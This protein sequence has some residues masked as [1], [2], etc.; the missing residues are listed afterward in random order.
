[1][2]RSKLSRLKSSTAK[3]A[4]SN[5]SNQNNLVRK[6][7]VS[8]VI[9]LSI[10]HWALRM[11]RR[12]GHISRPAWVSTLCRIHFRKNCDSFVV[13]CISSKVPLTLQ[14]WLAIFLVFYDLKRSSVA[15]LLNMVTGGSCCQVLFVD[16][17][18]LFEHLVSFHCCVACILRC[19]ILRCSWPLY[20]RSLFQTNLLC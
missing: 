16:P 11:G 6:F 5:V 7:L 18:D 20:Y 14:L 3:A 17:F 10:S 9:P 2:G 1:M 19:V 15:Q 4:V 8:F 12:P 13:R